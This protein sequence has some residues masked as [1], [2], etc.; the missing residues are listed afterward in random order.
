MLDFKKL[1]L[2]PSEPVYLQIVSFVKR[3]IFIGIVEQ[4]ESL[5]SRRE[6]A[7]LLK[8]NPNTVQKAFR[9]LEEEGL[10]VT[11]PN[12]VSII[13]WDEEIYAAIQKELTAGLVVDFVAQAKANGLTLDM[14]MA[15]LKDAWAKGDER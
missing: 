11:P 1:E 4:G 8:I 6:M 13:H 9:L 12:A 5:P 2:N 15:L 7:A 10:V 3:Q 14:V